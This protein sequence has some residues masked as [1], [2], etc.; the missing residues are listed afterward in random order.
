LPHVKDDKGTPRPLNELVA[1][2][3]L[4]KPQGRQV[5]HLDGNKRNCAPHNLAYAPDPDA[6]FDFYKHLMEETRTP[7]T[8][9]YRQDLAREQRRP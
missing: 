8:A 4:G 6:E 7:E 5:V 2:A 1:R 9:A 3:F